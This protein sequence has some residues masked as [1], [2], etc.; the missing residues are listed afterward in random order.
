MIDLRNETALS[1]SQAARLL[2]PSRRGRPV[3]LSCLL[4]W[5]LN[6]VRTPAGVVRLEAARMGSRWLTTIEALERFAAQQTPAVGD[7]PVTPRTPLRRQRA[8]GSA[9]KKLERL[10]I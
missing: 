7:K 2:P 10:G 9:A 8:S 4:R 5:V 1:L 3:T 6:G